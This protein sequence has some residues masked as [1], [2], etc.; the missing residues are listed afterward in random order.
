[1][2][3]SRN[4]YSKRGTTKCRLCGAVNPSSEYRR[5]SSGKAINACS[6]HALKPEQGRKKVFQ[7]PHLI[8]EDMGLISRIGFNY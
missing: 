3:A 4:I 5:D 1:M 8:T 2:P 7:M 6:K